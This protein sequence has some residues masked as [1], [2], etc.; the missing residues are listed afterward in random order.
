LFEKMKNILKKDDQV[1]V[2][3]S[4]VEFD[5]LEIRLKQ[6]KTL[7]NSIKEINLYSEILKSKQDFNIDNIDTLIYTNPK[8]V[9]NMIA[10]FGL[11]RLKNKKNIAIGITTAKVLNENGLNAF[12]CKGHSQHLL[13]ELVKYIKQEEVALCNN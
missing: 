11:E 10:I 12:V 1:L 8:E 5:D 7:S 2:I 4:F 13:D 6:L 3:K 9:K